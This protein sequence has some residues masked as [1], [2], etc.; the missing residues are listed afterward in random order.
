[1]MRVALIR[2]APLGTLAGHDKA[3]MRLA[4]LFAEIC[5]AKEEIF[6]LGRG[7]STRRVQGMTEHVLGSSGIAGRR[8]MLEE[9]AEFD[10][11]VVIVFDRE[12]A[13]VAAAYNRLH[14]DKC[15]IVVLTD[16][17]DVIYNFAL[18]VDSVGAP[19]PVKAILK[20]IYLWRQMHIYKKMIGVSTHIILPT[21]EDR[22]RLVEEIPSAK[23]K[24]YV[25]QL[26]PVG[27]MRKPRTIRRIRKILFVGACDYPPNA[28]AARIIEEEIA[29]A[30]PNKTFYVVGRGCTA[31]S[32]G[33]FSCLGEITDE[34]LQKRLGEA[35][36]CIA[37]LMHGTGFKSKVLDYLIAGKP[38]IGTSVAFQGFAARNGFNAIIE[39][40]PTKY[41]KRIRELDENP[42]LVARLQKN[43]PSILREFSE[44]RIREKF[45]TLCESLR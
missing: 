29:P 17:P 6:S 33:N 3:L 2:K 18:R 45:K 10:P 32:H 38:V 31:R 28:E 15:S 39:D 24:S 44:K 27:K 23:E 42:E 11:K 13:A 21:E 5:S 1:M 14:G 40:D 37:P 20:K 19:A 30:V 8:R 41:A 35:D 43:I 25:M 22:K 4:R 16:S 12:L 9:L 7:F 26:L 34:E 36:L